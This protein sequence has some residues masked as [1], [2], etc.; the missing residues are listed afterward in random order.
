V[1]GD[2][3]AGLVA[4]WDAQQA[5]YLP[6]RE[7]RFDLICDLVEEVAPPSPRILDLCAGPG[8][9]SARLLERLPHS[10]V[11]AVDFDPAHIELGRRRLGDRVTWHEIDLRRPDWDEHFAD[12]SFD[13][14][15]TATA[16]HWFTAEEIVRLYRSLAQLLSQGGLFANADHLTIGAPRIAAISAD[17]LARWKDEQLA[18]A[19][20]YA[21]YRAALRS[22]PALAEDVDAGDRLLGGR[23]PGSTL[24]IA[25]HQAALA[26]AGFA[27]A[28]EVWRHHTDALLVAL[29]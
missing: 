25:F 4:R 28:G 2:G 5:R 9:L 18:G 1:S 21:E 10:S 15:V 13:A 11:T 24:P 23:H 16:I 3:L 12:E 14:V 22:E 20:D 27:E 6:G 26:I 8:S 7:E 17:L 29:R 19:E